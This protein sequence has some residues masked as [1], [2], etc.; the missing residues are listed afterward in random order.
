MEILKALATVKP[1]DVASRD[2]LRKR[3]ARNE[4]ARVNIPE[5]RNIVRRERC[6]EDPE[7]FLR[8][9]FARIFY[10]PFAQ[11]HL[12]MIDAIWERAWTGGDK[13]IA[14]PRG[15]GKSQVT[16]AMVVNVMLATP[17]S[18]PVL[19]AATTKKARKMFSQIKNKFLDESR[20]DDF[21]AD[22][23]EITAPIRGLEGAPQRAAKQHVDGRLTR[24]IWSQD[25]VR[26]PEVA[27]SP[28]GGKSLVYFGL[29]S[30]IRGEGDEETRP[31]L[32]IIDDPETREVAFS[33]TSKHQDI[34]DMIDGDIAGLA[35]P[36]KTIPRV[37]LTTIQ[38]TECYSYRVTD[39]KL[40]PTFAGDRFPQLTSWPTNKDLWDEY[41]SLRQKDQAAGKKDGPT[42][43]QFYRDNFDAMKE[44]AVV[45]NPYRYV[46]ESNTDGDVIEL[47]ALAAFFNRV[48]DWGLEAVQAE[49]QQDPIKTDTT[50][51][52]K[53]TA[54]IVQTRM[55]GLRRRELP[56]VDEFKITVGLDIGKY[57]SHWT[58]IAL[59]GNA[60]GHVI[61]YGVMETHGLT[62]NSDETAIEQ[63]ILKSLMAWRVDIQAD[64]PADFVLVDS[65][66]YNQAVYEFV[67]QYGSPFAASKG[68]ASSKINMSQG[69]SATRLH[70]EHVRADLQ[71][72]EGIWL[73]NVETE[74]WKHQVQQRFLT[75]TFNEAH[76]LNDGSLSVWS[77]ESAK[78]HLSYAHHLVA[79]ERQERFIPGKGLVRKWVVTNK[80]NHWLDATALALAAGGVLGCKV[81]PREIKI[82]E[83]SSKPQPVSPKVQQQRFRQRPGGW[84]RGMKR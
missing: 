60:C 2:L 29:D 67:R 32:A 69:D 63:A 31:D 62:A 74:Y 39:R 7:L 52:G 8:T 83:S 72:T 5:P 26:L 37:V 78:D 3:E 73:Y 9:Y 65:G 36:N 57:F 4:G 81:I 56:K 55:S 47:D 54:G 75:A 22:F 46:K 49:L 13:A 27:G 17:I 15:D 82:P 12:K 33:P 41:L 48:A 80:N 58:K 70:F 16:I 40:K 1:T 76:E 6:M 21:I 79:E 28:W 14:A 25:R 64:N 19:V 71:T 35:G 59:H 38:N 20:Y 10:N 18:Y 44:G 66:D 34:E 45:A 77:T 50:E 30:A 43:T 68:W 84:M 24:I 51:R 42:A 11:H 23:P 61:D 53:L